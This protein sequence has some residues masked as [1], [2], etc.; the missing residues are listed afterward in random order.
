M[1]VLLMIF[2]TFLLLILILTI[3]AIFTPTIFDKPISI[4]I[5]PQTDKPVVKP[6][7]KPTDK[8]IVKPTDKPILPQTDN[9][10]VKPVDKPTDKPI[11]KPTDKPIVKPTDKPIIK[12]TDKPIVKPTDKPT[13]IPAKDM[14]LMNLLNQHRAS[15]G[16]AAVPV[17]NDAWKV[18]STHNFDLKNNNTGWS[19]KGQ[20][21]CSAHSWSNQPGKWTGCCYSLSSPNGPCMWNKPS[22]ITGN[23]LKGYEIG[24]GG[25][26]NMSPQSALNM[27]L[28]SAPHKAVIENTGTWANMRW[29]GLG[30]SLEHNQQGCWFLA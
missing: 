15:L 23:K 29:V 5:L 30:C 18:A 9:P 12:P 11:V 19:G 6:V 22:E 1:D 25:N 16:L 24:S 27:W 2:L 13:D 10:T 4:T 28:A 26:P 7:D 3:I 21:G 8:P 14:E 17:N 20:S